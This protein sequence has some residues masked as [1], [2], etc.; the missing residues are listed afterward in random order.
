MPEL[1]LPDRPTLG[2]IQR[3]ISEMAVQRGFDD[4]N[5]PNQFLQ[6]IEEVGELAKAARIAS[7]GKFAEDTSRKQASHE[8]ADVLI[9]LLDICN[10]LGIDAEVA[11]REKESINKTRTWS[12][13]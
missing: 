6:L 2:D 5:I 8:V 4:N 7:G 13:E 12:H 9:L 3:Y 11:L 1:I 10:R